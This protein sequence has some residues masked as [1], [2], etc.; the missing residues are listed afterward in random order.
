M[1]RIL[2]NNMSNDWFLGAP[3][4]MAQYALLTHL[5][6]HSVNMLPGEL[7]Y[8]VGDTHLYL[9][10]VEQAKEQ[11]SRAQ[12]VEKAQLQVLGQNRA[13]PKDYEFADLQLSNYHPLGKIAAPIAV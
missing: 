8:T 5:M 10:H 2:S 7:V 6:A 1:S 11:L 13:D 3:F 4:N 9:N 12:N